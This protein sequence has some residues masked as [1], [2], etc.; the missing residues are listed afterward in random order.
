MLGKTLLD[1]GQPIEA[2]VELR[3][4]LLQGQAESDV[5]PELVKALTAMG[6]A[7]EAI[8]TYAGKKFDSPAAMAELQVGLAAAWATQRVPEEYARSPIA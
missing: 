4:A 8:K 6:R 1:A 5:V 2:E 7:D 3:K